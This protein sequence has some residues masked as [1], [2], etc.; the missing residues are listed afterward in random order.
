MGYPPQQPG[1]C[2]S[3]QQTVY[4]ERSTR[5]EQYYQYN[6]GF[7]PNGIVLDRQIVMVDK[8]SV[9]RATEESVANTSKHGQ[10]SRRYED[11]SQQSLP[12]NSRTSRPP[13]PQRPPPNQRV[14]NLYYSVEPVGG[15][16]QYVGE[17]Y[18][19]HIVEQLG[20]PSARRIQTTNAVEYI[21]PR[22]R[23]HVPPPIDD[24]S[25]GT[26]EFYAGMFDVP[27][28]PL[29]DLG[30]SEEVKAISRITGTFI[31]KRL[32]SCPE[33]WKSVHQAHVDLLR[34][35]QEGGVKLYRYAIRP[36]RLLERF[37]TRFLAICKKLEK[38]KEKELYY[39]QGSFTG[40]IAQLLEELA[41]GIYK[42]YERACEERALKEVE[43]EEDFVRAT[44]DA[45][46]RLC[47]PHYGQRYIEQ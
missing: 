35:W 25:T 38:L 19:E 36:L 1:R 9:R 28:K 16:D 34:Y 33:D 20:E 11:R 22:S 40:P 18:S 47:S 6:L 2:S 23:S 46:R 3:R 4:A 12:A 42:C 39:D 8:G 32:F 29:G 37:E 41:G 31:T 17:P 21:R 30:T 27:I 44:V 13:R 45:D 15:Y 14:A 24:T 10:G 43:R 26:M 7:P 5:A